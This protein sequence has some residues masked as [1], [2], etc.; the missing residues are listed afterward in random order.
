MD[1]DLHNDSGYS[2]RICASSHGPSP[3]LSGASGPGDP[4]MRAGP[5]QAL[6]HPVQNINQEI[7]HPG[8]DLNQATHSDPHHLQASYQP[9]SQLTCKSNP[10]ISPPNYYSQS[11]PSNPLPSRPPNSYN[12]RPANSAGFLGTSQ[13]P[14]DLPCN[15]V[16]NAS[17]KNLL[18]SRTN[19]SSGPPQ[20]LGYSMHNSQ[21]IHSNRHAPNYRSQQTA[22][23]ISH[24]IQYYRS[25][26]AGKQSTPDIGPPQI[27]YPK[28]A[29]PYPI[30]TTQMPPNP[31]P[32]PP[33]PHQ[34]Y[35]PYG[36][37]REL[38][39]VITMGESSL[40]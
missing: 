18:Y 14:P 26:Q 31:Q 6:H 9:L 38:L 11:I 3:A 21:S 33:A 8:Q 24:P 15:S 10:T 19:S 36:H 37:R 22:V 1:H 20:T 25:Y 16:C 13:C 23:Q 28:A 7:H 2:T 4:E 39:D 29:P 32:H 35:Q 34:T 17:T 30:A 5:N 40:V 12:Y 27:S